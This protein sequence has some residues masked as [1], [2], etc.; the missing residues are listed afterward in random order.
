M[1][2]RP[3]SAVGACAC[4]DGGRRREPRRRCPREPPALPA[5]RSGG[6]EAG[7]R[8]GV[9]RQRRLGFRRPCRPRGRRRG[10]QPVSSC[11]DCGVP[12]ERSIR[13]STCR[14][15]LNN[16]LVERRTINW[17]KEISREFIGSSTPPL[18]CDSTDPNPDSTMFL[19]F[20]V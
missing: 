9:G 12:L 15:V 18:V 14:S 6:G 16:Q 19:F 11:L 8:G 10:G 13:T 20:G 1:L 5:T 7:V 2:L 4:S 17:W 3:A